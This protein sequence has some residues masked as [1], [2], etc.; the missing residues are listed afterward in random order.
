V[1]AA[2]CGALDSTAYASDICKADD[3]PTALKD[4]AK[5]CGKDP[6]TKGALADSETPH[7]CHTLFTAVAA[8]CTLADLTALEA[9][10][11]VGTSTELLTCTGTATTI[12]AVEASCTG[13]S[14]EYASTATCTT[15]EVEECAA[16]TA[17]DD[18]SACEAAGACTY[19]PAVADDTDTTDVDETEA[20]TCT[21]TVVAECAAATSSEAACTCAGACTFTA[22]TLKTCD[23]LDT[24]DASADCPTGCT[25][26]SASSENTPTCELDGAGVCPAGCTTTAK[27]CD[28]D[29]DTDGSAECPEGCDGGLHTRPLLNWP[30]SNTADG[31][32]E[33]IEKQEAQ[34]A[35]PQMCAY[36]NSAITRDPDCF[37]MAAGAPIFTSICDPDKCLPQLH[38]FADCCTGTDDGSVAFRG[39]PAGALGGCSAGA[40]GPAGADLGGSYSLHTN[41]G[42]CTTT[43][44]T[45]CAT[46]TDLDD[47]TACEAAGACTYVPASCEAGTAASCTTTPVAA[48]ALV[49]AL[50]DVTACEAAGD[51]TY[52]ATSAPITCPSMADYPNYNP[53]GTTDDTTA[54][55]ASHG[56]MAAANVAGLLAVI[57]SLR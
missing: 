38:A 53:V 42:T 26:V 1:L 36:A 11:C 2:A 5:V 3:S 13:T 33:A 14:T 37:N 9:A 15:T 46:V 29:A 40:M 31:L 52:T 16:V 23:L 18:A 12:A 30:D 7:Q 34:C 22:A 50:D 49:T 55:K 51:C 39:L 43:E 19:A 56:V 45:E 24:T 25:E 41:A 44:V 35:T 6:V 28:L 32:F 4:F 20:A 57:A 17:L 48:C 10:G 21:T 54:D 8:S 27:T 47:A